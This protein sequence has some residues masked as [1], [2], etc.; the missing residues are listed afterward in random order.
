MSVFY[1]ESMFMYL[2][3]LVLFYKM[4][5]KI[6]TIELDNKCIKLQIWDT[7]GQERVCT[8][9]SSFGCSLSAV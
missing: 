1:D 9:T 5:Y 4:D 3:T 7:T 2:K 6:R 8:I